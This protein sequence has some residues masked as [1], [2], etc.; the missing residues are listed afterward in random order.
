MLAAAAA[1]VLVGGAAVAITRLGDDDTQQVTAGPADPCDEGEDLLALTVPTGPVSP[2]PY[3]GY[4]SIAVTTLSSGSLHYLTD[5]ERVVVTDPSF[6]PDGHE[7]AVV[8]ADGDY[9]SA[10]PASTSIWVVDLDAGN[11]RPITLGRNDGS[12][13]WSPDGS[14]IAFTHH[15]ENGG[16]EIKTVPP[17][18]GEPNTLVEV[19]E[20][21]NGH[22]LAWSA[23]GTMIVTW[24]TTFS[25]D[26]TS[27]G[28]VVLLAE[29]DGRATEVA[30]IEE[31]IYDATPVPG[32]NDLMIRVLDPLT[33]SSGHEILDLATAERRPVEAPEGVVRFSSD[34]ERAYMFV[35]SSS[36]TVGTSSADF[37]GRTIS[38]SG[39]SIAEDL[40]VTGIAV[41]PCAT[42]HDQKHTPAPDQPLIGTDWRLGP[43]RLEVTADP[44]D[45][46]CGTLRCARLRLEVETDSSSDPSC[47]V[48][49]GE[50]VGDKFTVDPE[51]ASGAGSCATPGE[52]GSGQT[53]VPT[54]LSVSGDMLEIDFTSETPAGDYTRT[55]TFGAYYLAE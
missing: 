32:T 18:G 26:G 38:P 13:S 16:Y 31:S 33:G 52:L 27:T 28:S 5:P 22:G 43:R 8:W 47:L 35:T 6:S 3:D 36:G 39:P 37:D 54:R 20:N 40:Y 14:L 10:G 15:L 41:G 50:L 29:V 44:D 53:G 51:P 7:M 34:G 9:E 45:D 49:S 11:A 21:T 42:G 19:S 1:M 17:G 25:D 30:R 46:S 55:E 4:F 48:V 24:Y 23:D 12:P 2:V